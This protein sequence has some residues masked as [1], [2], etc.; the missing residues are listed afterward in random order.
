MPLFSLFAVISLVTNGVTCSRIQMTRT[1]SDVEIRAANELRQT[2]KKMVYTDMN[3]VISPGPDFSDSKFRPVE[4]L[5]VTEKDAGAAL[6]PARAREK[7]AA[8]SNSEAFVI[9]TREDRG[10]GKGVCIAGKSP[11]AVYYGVYA[12]L[13]DYLGCGFYHFGPDGTVIPKKKTIEVPDDIFDFRE[14]WI[15]YRRMSCWSGS[16]KPFDILEVFAWQAKRSFQWILDGTL[17]GRYS[18]PEKDMTFARLSN[19]PFLGGGEP[20]TNVAVP[21]SLFAEHPEYFTLIDGKRV[22][23]RYPARRCYSNPGVR[24][25]F[26][27]YA[28]RFSDY[29]G[30]VALQLTD[31]TGGWCECEACRAYGTGDDG[32]WTSYNLAHRFMSEAAAD[33]LAQRP[34]ADVIVDAYLQWRELPKLKINTDARVKCVFAPHQRCYV[35]SLDDPTADCNRHFNRLYKGWR[36]LYPRNGIFDYYCYSFTEYSPVEYVF[37]EDMKYYHSC[38]LDHFVEDTSN[39]SIVQP[40]PLNNWQFYYVFSKM[41]WDPSL[42]VEKEL[43]KAYRRYY[44]KAAEPMI[45]YHAFRRR[46]WESA[47]GHSFMGCRPRQGYCLQ[48]E[49]AFER[50]DAYLTA[51]AALAKGDKDVESRVARDRACLEGIWAKR[52]NDIKDRFR[53]QG[54]VPFGALDPSRPVKIDGSLDEKGWTDIAFLSGF[55]TSVGSAPKAQTWMRAAFDADGL[56]FGIEALAPRDSQADDRVRVTLV[57][58]AGKKHSLVVSAASSRTS[59]M[60]VTAHDDRYVAEVRVPYAALG[61]SGVKTGDDWTVHV[62]RRAAGGETSSLDG[63]KASDVKRFR[64]ASFGP[65]RVVDGFFAEKK[66]GFLAHFGSDRPKLVTNE[67]DRVSVKLEKGAVLYT[68]SLLDTDHRAKEPTLLKGSVTASGSGTII[69]IVPYFTLEP[70]SG[71]RLPGRVRVGELPI[72]P[73]PKGIPFTAEIP[74]GARA[75]LHVYGKDA[76]IDGLEITK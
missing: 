58:P 46:L 34:D 33:I 64:R 47:P 24:K 6:L 43:A 74:P 27:D 5:L 32:K 22:P 15:R 26:V 75:S 31:K 25:L 71:K 2:I 17:R 51:A 68:L 72:G 23:G 65:N 61:V 62:A 19:V 37:A 39:G 60:A 76:R 52:W 28:V 56:L 53:G 4:I 67:F 36:K 9:A 42:D 69:V 55:R 50:L 35:H 59:D 30:S 49:G 73:E 13:E 40:Y 20:F 38:G 45:R 18:F 8:T 70:G 16:V 57:S 10:C 63:V 3:Y 41:I 29:G 48:P 1:A 12:F 54:V 21:D 7:L 11:I 44:G 14:P 66:G